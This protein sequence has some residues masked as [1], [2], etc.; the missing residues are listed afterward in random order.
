MRKLSK[1]QA[2]GL[3]LLALIPLFVL[4][5][6]A[7]ESYGRARVHDADLLLERQA[8]PRSRNALGYLD[9]AYRELNRENPAW[10]ASLDES[11]DSALLVALMEKHQNALSL[12][13][14]ALELGTLQ[15]PAYDLLVRVH[16]RGEYEMGQLLGLRARLRGL[17]GKPLEATEDALRILRLG[18]MLVRA[19][20]GLG[21][22]GTADEL[23]R[24]GLA[25]LREHVA[26]DVSASTL[27]SILQRVQAFEPDTDVFRESV[28]LQYSTISSIFDDPVRFRAEV[29]RIYQSLQFWG[30]AGEAPKLALHSR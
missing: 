17:E 13:E 28:Q 9:R 14:Q 5:Y 29:D 6:N 19:Q 4:V 22:Y 23:R 2:A 3:A 15:V 1:K 10:D 11:T 18:D 26:Q 27:K 24:M 7:V 21:D 25:A 20:D 8:L 30:K 12:L 16:A